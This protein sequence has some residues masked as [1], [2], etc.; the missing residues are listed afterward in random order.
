LDKG[1][2][3]TFMHHNRKHQHVCL[4][5]NGIQARGMPVLH[6]DSHIFSYTVQQKNTDVASYPY[7]FK[8]TTTLTLM[9]LSLFVLILVI[10]TVHTILPP[11]TVSCPSFGSLL[12][13]MSWRSMPL[14][15]CSFPGDPRYT[16]MTL[17]ANEEE[18]TC[19]GGE[20][21][22]DFLCSRQH[23]AVHGL[24]KVCI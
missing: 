20:R 4:D 7:L 11:S 6:V 22:F 10:T 9:H 17:T 23:F 19:L 1:Y 16:K 12:S 21:I 2:Y 3:V 14:R 8:N 15:A 5:F 13:T 18:F 24:A